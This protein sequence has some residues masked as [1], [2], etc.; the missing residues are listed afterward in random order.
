MFYGTYG[1]DSQAAMRIPDGGPAPETIESEPYVPG[2]LAT[3]I[4]KYMRVEFMIGPTLTDRTG[5]LDKVGASYIILRAPN[6]DLLVCDLFSIKFVSVMR[7]APQ[8]F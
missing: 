3:Q 7:Q 8:G 1:K 2:Y 5:I 4:G 6:G